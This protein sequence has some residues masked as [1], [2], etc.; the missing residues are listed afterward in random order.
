MKPADILLQALHNLRRRL[1]RTILTAIGVM[2][3]C[4]SIVVMVSIGVGLS[5][6]T[7]EMMAGMGDLTLIQI[8]GK[9]DGMLEDTDLHAI[10]E[11]P[12]VK[13]VIAKQSCSDFMT[14][15]TA[16]NSRYQ[17]GWAN[18]AGV[19]RDLLEEAGYKTREGSLNLAKTTSAIP[20]LLGQN[21][22]YSFRDTAR[23]EG[24][25]IVDRYTMDENGN[26][27]DA[28]APDPWFDPMK[29]DLTLTLSNPMDE[30]AAPYQVLLHPVGILEENM[31]LGYETSEGFIMDQKDLQEIMENASRQFGTASPKKNYSE[32]AVKTAVMEDV[33]DAEASLKTAGY[34]TNSYKSLRD[35]M[36]EQTRTMQLVLGGLGAIS[37]LV[38]AI[39]ITNTMIM[40]ITERTREI[41]IMKALGC[42]SRDIRML[43]LAESGLIGLAG[44]MAGILLSFAISLGMNHVAGMELSVIPWWLV[45]LGLGFSL[46][47][48]L[49]SGFFPAARAVKIP[50]VEALRQ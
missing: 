9:A 24:Q 34:M 10:Q 38:A 23:P 1:S 32:I 39:G 40:S 17:S 49:V 14:A 11:T 12:K 16:A 37:L 48:G 30:T 43:F 41:G 4:T 20:V 6:T 15:I 21:T 22:A 3:G 35:S 29:T 25:D 27:T 13:T 46:L 44:G 8:M 47:I 7:E 42:R 36:D 31:S 45:L 18:I 28:N 26:F 33:P 2:I 50:A 19:D 5:K